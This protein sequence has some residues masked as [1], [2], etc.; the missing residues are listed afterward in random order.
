[1]DIIIKETGERKELTRRDDDGIDWAG[2][3]ILGN[4][5][6]IERDDDNA[7]VM[8]Q[9]TYQW[10]ADTIA[11]HEAMDA[12]ITEY[13]NSYGRAAVEDCINTMRALTGDLEDQPAAVH[14]ALLEWL[15]D[16]KP[17]YR[18]IAEDR[19]LWETQVDPGNDDPEM[20]DALDVD[21]KMDLIY[22]LFGLN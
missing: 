10:W 3:F 7:V 6:D 2:E 16:I 15:H 19:N 11:A 21:D 14:R 17:T 9:P 12:E 18:E 22:G 13:R 8:S 5:P 1:M 20:F 4:S